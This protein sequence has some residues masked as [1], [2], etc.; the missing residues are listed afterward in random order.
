MAFVTTVVENWLEQ[1]IAQWVPYEES[2]HC[3]TAPGAGALPQSSVLLQI[4]ASAQRLV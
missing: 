4:P 1:E 3:P 2:I